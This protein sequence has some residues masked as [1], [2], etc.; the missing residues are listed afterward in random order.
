MSKRNRENVNDKPKKRS[1]AKL[2]ITIILCIFSVIAAMIAI[3]A[4]IL[5][6]K[7]SQVETV[8]LDP[9]ELMINFEIE[10]SVDFGDGYL[11]VAIFGVDS[12][13][14]ELE[15]GT[16][17][18]TIIIASL[19]NETKE[20]KLVSVYRDTYLNLSE[21][22]YMKCNAAYS[23]G[24]A[25]LA[26]NMLNTNLDLDIDKF[27]TVDFTVITE[28]VDILGGIELEIEESE[29]DAINEYIAETAS[30]AG[31]EGIEFTEAGLQVVDGVQA[32]TYA[33]IRSTS[34]GDYKRTD[35]QRYVIEQIVD[36]VKTCDLATLMDL[37]DEVLPQI[38][39]NFTAT[40]IA[41]YAAAYMDIE[42]GETM[43]WP[44]IITVGTVPSVGSVVIPLDLESNVIDLHEFLFPEL[45][46]EPS[47]TVISN[48]Y[49][50]YSRTS[51]YSSGSLN[52]N[53]AYET[54]SENSVTNVL[55]AE[56]EEADDE[57]TEDETTE[58]EIVDDID[59][60]IEAETSINYEKFNNPVLEFNDD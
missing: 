10:E 60:E 16:L 35:R 52:T 46:Y 6:G 57:T 40:E 13:E 33:R 23:F 7:L 49:E 28:I 14:G 24:G 9:D 8:E 27:I 39:T 25:T 29:I 32:T 38:L 41:Y 12:R 19:N 18:D 22:T 34:G 21:G 4:A 47:S 26:I 15:S 56:I 11:N 48:S 44:E 5:L 58:D 3:A 2:V 30:V 1:K 31:K 36:K 50:I 55:L 59:V 53:T 51:N 42:L 17:S 20:V 43:G 54:N 37:I 45:E